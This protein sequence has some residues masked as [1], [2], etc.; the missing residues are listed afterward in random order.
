MPTTRLLAAGLRMDPS[1]SVP[2][3]TAQRF[4]AT[5]TADPELEPD[6]SKPRRYGSRVNPPRALHPL[7]EP[8]P[9]A[10]AHSDRLAFPRITAPALRSRD[11][12]FASCGTRLPYEGKR[13]GCRLHVIIGSDVV[14]DQHRDTVE[15]AAHAP[16]PTLVVALGGDRD[17]VRIRFDH[18]AEQSIDPLDPVKVSKR[19][20]AARELAGAHQSLQLRNRRLDPG[21]GT[22]GPGDVRARF[23]PSG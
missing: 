4:A 20:L 23:P 12:I 1:V 3:A 14:L 6:G 15:R 21:A 16:R 17:G 13:P 9:R 22:D 2:T 18:R 10:F 19:Q 8:K 5:A 7:M 11:T